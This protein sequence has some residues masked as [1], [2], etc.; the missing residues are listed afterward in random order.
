MAVGPV[1]QWQQHSLPIDSCRLNTSL[2]TVGILWS[3]AATS[4]YCAVHHRSTQLHCPPSTRQWQ[5]TAHKRQCGCVHRTQRREHV[6][7]RFAFLILHPALSHLILPTCWRLG[8]TVFEQ[9][10]ALSPCPATRLLSCPAS[11]LS[12]CWPPPSCSR[13]LP[14]SC[15]PPHP[16]PWRTRRSSASAAVWTCTRSLS[17]L[18]GQQHAAHTDGRLPCHRTGP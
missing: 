6:Q 14:L 18:H 2:S 7:A 15:R 11:L 16:R 12:Q 4:V 8:L 9:H 3:S 17:K 10:F 5:R 1:G 13:S